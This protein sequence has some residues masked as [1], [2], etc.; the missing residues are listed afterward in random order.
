[1]RCCLRRRRTRDPS[2]SRRISDGDT[3]TSPSSWRCSGQHFWII[4]T[5]FL[6]FYLFSRSLASRGELLPIYNKAKE[7]TMEIEKKKKDKKAAA[8]V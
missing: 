3:T 5:M 7:K 2:G 6:Y 1:M 8:K 4:S